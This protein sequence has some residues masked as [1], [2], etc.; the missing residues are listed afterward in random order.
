[1]SQH[2][3]NGVSSCV[4]ARLLDLGILQFKDS[5]AESA[6]LRASSS[7]YSPIV[8]SPAIVIARA[9]SHAA[10]STKSTG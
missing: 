3:F 8:P 4:H 5:T 7:R 6:F 10:H 1:M 2:I 9:L